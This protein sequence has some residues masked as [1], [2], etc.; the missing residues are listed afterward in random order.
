MKIEVR[1][2]SSPLRIEAADV[3]DCGAIAR[4]D[5]IVR[6]TE[7]GRSITAIEYEAYQPMAENLIRQ[8][9]A[10]LHAEHSFALARVHHRIGVV[11]VGEAA[12]ILDVHSRHRGEAFAVV[13]KFMDRLKLDVPIWKAR[14]H[15]S[16]DD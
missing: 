2:A 3:S 9:L 4:F 8:I 12:I 14:V 6:G 16:H 13:T 10:D 11:P 7:D 1:I 15:F 5:G